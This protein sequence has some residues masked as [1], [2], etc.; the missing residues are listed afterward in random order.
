MKTLTL[1]LSTPSCLFASS[2]RSPPLSSNERKRRLPPQPPW[3]SRFF[4]AC[5]PPQSLSTPSP[6]SKSVASAGQTR[7]TVSIFAT[8]AAMIKKGA[9]PKRRRLKMR[10]FGGLLLVCHRRVSR[11][12]DCMG[13]K[14]AGACCWRQQGTEFKHAARRNNEAITP[15]FS[16]LVRRDWP[17]SSL[18]FFFFFLFFNLRPPSHVR[19]L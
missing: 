6:G 7:G 16:M 4:P 8:T 13:Q 17:N 3:P 15:F 18:R 9:R 12:R 1:P 2:H 11:F 5:A 14:G 19:P 10:S